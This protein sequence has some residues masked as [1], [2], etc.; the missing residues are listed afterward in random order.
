MD[1]PERHQVLIS[2]VASS[3]AAIPLAYAFAHAELARWWGE[4]PVA[5][6][7]LFGIGLALSLAGA[8]IARYLPLPRIR[9]STQFR[10][11][12]HGGVVGLSFGAIAGAVAWFLADVSLW[13]LLIWFFFGAVLLSGAQ[14]ML[15]RP[16]RPDG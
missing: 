9:A 14:V 12:V 10:H 11:A 8:A 1:P 4:H 5:L 3:I 16:A 13:A 7:V 6:V 2:A 15:P